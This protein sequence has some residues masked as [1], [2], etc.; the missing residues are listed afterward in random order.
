MSHPDEPEGDPSPPSADREAEE[1]EEEEE[2]EDLPSVDQI[3]GT[4]MKESAL[5]PVLIVLLGTAGAFG[6]AMLVLSWVDHNPFAAAALL[7]LLGMTIDVTVRSRS[8]PSLRNL[9]RLVALIWAVAAGFA[10]IAI[11]SGIAY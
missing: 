9:A 10:G 5:W 8:N 1:G 2:G 4:F 7:L 11:W 3:I 6:G